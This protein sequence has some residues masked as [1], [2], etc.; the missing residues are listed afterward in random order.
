M[1]KY[2]RYIVERVLDYGDWEDWLLIRDHYGLE[3]LKEIAFGIRSL[4]PEYL[5]FIA[6]VTYT[7][8]NQFRCYTLLQSKNLH[9]YF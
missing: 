9:W 8:E 2:A 7:P 4:F 5:S 3:K 6:T 1:E